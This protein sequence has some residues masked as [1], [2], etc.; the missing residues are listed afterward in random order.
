VQH[1]PAGFSASL[2]R[3]LSAVGPIRVVEAFDGQVIDRGCAYLAP[4]GKHMT[5]VGG[6]DSTLIRLTD[7]PPRHGV[8]PAADLLFESAARVFGD[9]SVGVVLTGMGSDGAMGALAIKRAGGDVIVQDEASS[10]IWGM[11]G[12]VVRFGAHN[13]TVDIEQVAAEIRRSVKARSGVNVS[14]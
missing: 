7:G 12:S 8:C 4:Y 5:V 13:R 14:G 9:H 3:R 11:P 6:R 2:A 1:L 10:V